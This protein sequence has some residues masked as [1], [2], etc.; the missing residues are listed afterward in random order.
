MKKQQEIIE[1]LQSLE[2]QY[3]ELRDIHH[4]LHSVDDKDKW[5]KDLLA[6]TAAKGAIDILKWVLILNSTK[7]KE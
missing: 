2:I 5:E 4:Q 1:K 6:L 7:P 3:T